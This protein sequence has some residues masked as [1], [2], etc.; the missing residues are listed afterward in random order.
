MK[1][2]K[3]NIVIFT[4]IFAIILGLSFYVKSSFKKDIQ[5]LSN[6]IEEELAKIVE[7]SAVKYNYTNVVSFKD[8]KKISN[9]NI[10]FTSKSFLIKYS[11]YIK[12]GVDLD[13]VEIDIKDTKKAKIY[14]DKPKILDNVI[15]E[16]DVYIYDEKSSVFNK[17]SF[18]DLYQVLIEEKEKVA[19]E[20][21]EKGLLN[22]AE[23][24][25]KNILDSLFKSLGFES[26]DIEFKQ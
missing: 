17:L 3:R 20:V 6:T 13:S 2:W 24:N 10:P 1:R 15:N 19:D 23:R 5:L 16:E 21:I 22:D 9:L 11:G 25:V 12:A 4:L 8:S 18:E 26:I 7:L 14:L